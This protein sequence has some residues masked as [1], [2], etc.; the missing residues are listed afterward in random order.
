MLAYT[1]AAQIAALDLIGDGDG[2][3]KLALISPATITGAIA[4]VESWKI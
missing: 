4:L 2:A 1:G 3:D